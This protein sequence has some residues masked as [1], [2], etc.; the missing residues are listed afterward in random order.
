MAIRSGIVVQIMEAIRARGGQ[1]GGDINMAII[2]NLHPFD[3][4]LRAP[5]KLAPVHMCIMWVAYASRPP[6]DRTWTVSVSSP[7]LFSLFRLRN[8]GLPTQECPCCGSGPTS[9]RRGSARTASTSTRIL[10]EVSAY[11]YAPNHAISSALKEPG[12]VLIRCFIF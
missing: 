7:I 12:L 6:S 4:R 5:F 1:S 8:S 2:R 10:P 9:R 3:R 11:T